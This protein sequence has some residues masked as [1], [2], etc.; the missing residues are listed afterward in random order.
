MGNVILAAGLGGLFSKYLPLIAVIVALALLFLIFRIVGLKLRIIWKLLINS[1]CGALMLVVFDFI[2]YSV[3]GM[4]FFYIDVTWLNS[5]IAGVLGIP[6]VI[7]L[8]VLKFL[9]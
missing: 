9:I 3:L 7:L 8:L 4:E 1:I 5:A 6:G 2:F